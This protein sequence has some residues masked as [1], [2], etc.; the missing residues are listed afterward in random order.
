MRPNFMSVGGYDGMQLTY[1]A[2]KKTDGKSDGDSLIGA[3]KG[4]QWESPR[5]QIL[6]DPDTREIVQKHLYSQGGE[7]E[8]A[9]L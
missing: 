1:E 2:L 9:T 7:G 5:G 4:M 8:R 3:M 6:I